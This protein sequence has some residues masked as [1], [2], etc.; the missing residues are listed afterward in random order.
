MSTNFTQVHL[1]TAGSHAIV[2]VVVGLLCGG[3]DSRSS[4]QELDQIKAV[5]VPQEV[6]IE[7]ARD[8]KNYV[9][10]QDKNK[11]LK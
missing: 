8:V 10:I 3:L 2:V 7:D 1:C 6:V 9:F 11:L 5:P 4:G